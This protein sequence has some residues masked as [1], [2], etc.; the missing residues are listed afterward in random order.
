MRILH[1]LNWKLDDVDKILDIVKF[2]NFDAIQIN[3][4]QPLKED[5]LDNWWLAYQPCGFSIGNQYGS[6]EDLKKL[7]DDAHSR[8][9]LIFSDVICTHV[10]GKNDGRL[11]PHEKVDSKLVDN[12]YFWREKKYITDWDSRYQA[13][14]Y[15]AGLPSFDLSNWDLQNIITDFLNELIDCGV[16]GFRFDS[17]KS[18]KTPVEGSDFFPRVLGHLKK[19]VY[20]YGEV[21]FASE[22][23]IS[24]YSDY[25]DVLTNTWSRNKDSVVVFSESHDSYYEFGY[26]KNRTSREITNDYRLLSHNYPKTIYYAR[27][28]DPEWMSSEVRDV[29][30]N[31]KTDNLVY[32]KK[33]AMY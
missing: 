4:I 32:V 17:A 8:D 11:E 23:L 6:K 21:I 3:P 25:L 10:A 1:L 7:C 12:K 16:D 26:T 18:I 2:Q 14:N 5:G 24:L 9:I 30:V 15:C 19:D 13:V 27:S 33:R 20:S 22:E 31:E 29:N 28:F